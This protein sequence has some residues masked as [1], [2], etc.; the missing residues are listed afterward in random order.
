MAFR[1][2]VL[3]SRGTLGSVFMRMLGAEARGLDLPELDVADAAMLKRA[4][5][6]GCPEYVINCAALTDV[7]ECERHPGRA[8]AVHRD[9]VGA[10]VSAAPKLITFSTDQVFSGP[11]ETPWLEADLPDPPNQYAMSKLEG[12]KMALG[13]ADSLVIRTSWLFGGRSGLVPFFEARLAGGGIVR[14]VVDQKASVTYAPDLANCVLRMTGEDARG[15]F[16]IAS[17]GG[18]TPYELA[19]YLSGGIGESI[20]PIRW[21]DLGLPAKRPSYSVLGTLSRYVLPDWRDA[22][23]RWRLG[24]D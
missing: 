8:F 5:A 15:L 18:M 6:E 20:A 4:I 24:D 21:A 13:R 10:L 16:H 7:D 12:E 14:A 17:P 1:Y 19:V 3:G 23:D 9:A 11:R 2:L 22:I